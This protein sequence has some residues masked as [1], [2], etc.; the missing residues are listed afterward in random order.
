MLAALAAAPAAHAQVAVDHESTVV[1][2]QAGNGN[3]IAE[4]GETLALTENVLSVEF[5]TLTGVTGTLSSATPGVTIAAADAAW[6]DLDFASIAGNLTP[7]SATLPTTLP[8]GVPASFS[9]ALTTSLGPGQ[10]S[11]SVP[12]GTAGAYA[13]TNATGLPAAIP[14][15]GTL[16]LPLTL[17]TSGNAKGLRVRIGSITHPYDGDLRL[18]LIA[19]DGRSVVLADR[20]GGPGQDWVDAVFDD[21]AA[22]SV[23]AA[24][25]P[26]TGSLRPEQA[27]STLDG[28]PL[29]G[30]WTLRVTDTSPGQA[31]S[32]GAWGL[33]AAPA[34]CAPAVAPTPGPP[35]FAHR[36]PN[37]NGKGPKKK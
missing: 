13:S 16:D 2:E 12:T 8:C 36:S 19:P 18:T 6:P 29:A 26:F 15:P 37:A 32:V 21:A 14:D 5:D 35:G 10:V 34:V 31:G 27:L 22:T 3:G 33:D 25:A 20:R 17:G 9:V 24:S 11:F 23:L 30:T 4:P 7:F 28:A 1:A